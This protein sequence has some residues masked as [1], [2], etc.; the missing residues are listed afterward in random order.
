MLELKELLGELEAPK[1]ENAQCLKRDHLLL[2][3]KRKRRNHK[4]LELAERARYNPRY[5]EEYERLLRNLEY[6]HAYMWLP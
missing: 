3:A 5:Y 2:A 4:L 6:L 1:E